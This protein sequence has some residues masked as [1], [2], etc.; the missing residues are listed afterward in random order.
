MIII[1]RKNRTKWK[2]FGKKINKVEQ[3]K[4]EI[5]IFANRKRVSLNNLY[6]G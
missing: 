3:F 6:Y 2:I 4:K 5:C 1:L